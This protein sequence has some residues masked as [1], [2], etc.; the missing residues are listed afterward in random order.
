MLQGFVIESIL[1]LSAAVRV[2]FRSRSDLAPGV[3]ALRQQ[4]AV[5]KG[6]RPRPRLNSLDRLFWTTLRRAWTRWAD[7]LAIVKPETVVTT[8]DRSPVV[9]LYRT[10]AHSSATGYDRILKK[11]LKPYFGEK[12]LSA[13]DRLAI[14]EF[15]RLL[16]NAGRAPQTQRNVLCCLSSVLQNAVSFQLLTG[17]PVRRVNITEQ[18]EWI[19]A[20]AAELEPEQRIPTP[21]EFEL[22]LGSVDEPVRT[23]VLLVAL[24]GLRIGELIALK[25]RDV[26]LGVATL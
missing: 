26:D 21:A 20:T 23:M 15:M 22:Y 10:V 11:H 1:A 19:E 16:S 3:L 25:W 2:F 7:V 4:V 12:E 5:L 13:V 9:Q 24:L 8:F 18:T 6:R 14:T 17:N